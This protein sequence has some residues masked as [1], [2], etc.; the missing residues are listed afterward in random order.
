MEQHVPL[1]MVMALNVLPSK[2][3]PVPKDVPTEGPCPVW[4]SPTGKALG[5]VDG[6]VQEVV[7]ENKHLAQRVVDLEKELTDAKGQCM[8]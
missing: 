6:G 5:G 3:P 4:S 7:D 2:Q 1:G 8:H